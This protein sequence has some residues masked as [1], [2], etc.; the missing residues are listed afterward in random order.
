MENFFHI[1]FIY[2]HFPFI[3]HK[4]KSLVY[5]L[6]TLSLIY[7]KKLHTYRAYYKLTPIS[8]LQRPVTTH[9]SI[10][11]LPISLT[12][13]SKTTRNIPPKLETW[14]QQKFV[15]K[16]MRVWWAFRASHT[17]L[18]FFDSSLWR[19]APPYNYCC[20]IYFCHM[21]TSAQSV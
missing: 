2:N 8:H 18:K 6:N 19:N 11:T 12:F 16:K 7:S 3:K 21:T 14:E 17:K 4:E 15:W 10:G 5:K 1:Q 9:N 20:Q 13:H